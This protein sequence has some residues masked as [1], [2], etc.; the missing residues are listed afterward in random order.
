MNNREIAKALGLT[1]AAVREIV[2]SATQK[3]LDGLI[4]RGFRK[5][6]YF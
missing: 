1:E 4:Q 5:E 3:L 2:Q 6:D